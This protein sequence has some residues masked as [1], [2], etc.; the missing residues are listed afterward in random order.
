MEKGKAMMAEEKSY[1]LRGGSNFIQSTN[2]A[3]GNHLSCVTYDPKLRPIITCHLLLILINREGSIIL[4]VEGLER[5]Q[6][7]INARLK[8][9]VRRVIFFI[10]FFLNM[11][12]NILEKYYCD[13]RYNVTEK[14]EKKTD[15][16]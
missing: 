9:H 8:L 1:F 15:Y 5:R 2:Y 6:Q 7:G 14:N 16:I 3:T 4:Q 11:C 12:S 10:K 13:K